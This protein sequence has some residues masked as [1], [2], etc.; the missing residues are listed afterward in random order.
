MGLGFFLRWK[1]DE[2]SRILKKVWIPLA[3]SLVVAF[4][5][6]L[7]IISDFNLKTSFGLFLGSWVALAALMWVVSLGR[8]PFKLPLSAWGSVIAH[9]GMAMTVIGITLVSIYD[10]EKDVRL[11]VGQSYK[12]AGYEFTFKKIESIKVDNYIANRATL[13]VTQDGKLVN[14]MY[15]EKRDYGRDQ[16]PMTEAGIDAG[17]TRDLFAALG[18]PLGNDAWSFRLYHKPFVRWIWLGGVLMGLGGLI[19]AFDRRYRRMRKIV[20]TPERSNLELNT[21]QSDTSGVTV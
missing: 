7:L 10:T 12:L 16:M 3:V 4:I 1:K 13:D 2:P 18:E 17:F 14:N 9:I 6:P 15:P 8:S 5:L 19:A 21:K 11:E 20:V